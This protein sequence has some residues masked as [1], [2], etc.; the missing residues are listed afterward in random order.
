MCSVTQSCLTLCDSMDCNPPGSTVHGILQARILEWVDSHSLLQVVFTREEC[1]YPALQAD[2]L[3]YE[4][5][6]KLCQGASRK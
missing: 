2:S 3:P 5:A 6:G 1:S 4:A